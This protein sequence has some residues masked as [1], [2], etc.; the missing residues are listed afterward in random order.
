MYKSSYESGPYHPIS[1]P[2]YNV[3]LTAKALRDIFTTCADFEMRE[4]AFGL[5]KNVR[6]SVCWLDGVVSGGDVS[7]CVLRPLTQSARAANARDE[8]QA[9]YAI[10]HGGVYS[11]SVHECTTTDDTVAAL[12]HGHCAVIF[13][14][15]QTALCFEVKS[16]KTRGVSEPT[17]EKSL[18]GA[19]DSFVETDMLTEAEGRGEHRRAQERD[20]RGGDVRGGRRP[21]GDCA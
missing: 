10:I 11:Y 4:V 16:D 2:E 9:L 3:P 6:L 14:T 21:A 20:A 13:D 19:K 5:E 12:T 18:K 15:L 8:A 17:L 1:L 7:T